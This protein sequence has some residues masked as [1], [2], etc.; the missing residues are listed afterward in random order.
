M[1]N[2]Q[3]FDNEIRER[4][5]AHENASTQKGDWEAVQRLLDD[6]NDTPVMAGLNGSVS[7]LRMRVILAAS[8][9]LLAI[10]TFVLFL[11]PNQSHNGTNTTDQTVLLGSKENGLPNSTS[12]KT[13]SKLRDNNSKVSRASKEELEVEISLEQ[14]KTLGMLDKS[15][16]KPIYAKSNVHKRIS[17]EANNGGQQQKTLDEVMSD[18]KKLNRSYLS[19]KN[20]ADHN[21]QENRIGSILDSVK[22]T[23]TNPTALKTVDT[24]RFALPT[25][26]AQIQIAKKDSDSRE[27]KTDTTTLLLNLA[28]VEKDT[29]SIAANLKRPKS[30]KH[31]NTYHVTAGIGYSTYHH[32]SSGQLLGEVSYRY[33]RNQLFIEASLGYEQNMFEQVTSTIGQ[34]QYFLEK[35]EVTYKL[36]IYR[37]SY[38]KN[39]LL[40]GYQINNIRIYSG[41]T[42]GY[43]LNSRASLQKTDAKGNQKYT[44]LETQ[45]YINGLNEFTHGLFAGGEYAIG[46]ISLGLRAH[47]YKRYRV[48]AGNSTFN[49]FQFYAKYMFK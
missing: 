34:Q 35:E 45:G 39:I 16:K 46:K 29:T 10:P 38:L 40:V 5:A 22:H 17:H 20:T 7:K 33:N 4:F 21:R 2:E 13:Q 14:K 26:Q 36:N 11:L 9:I 8:I 27:L 1:S 25:E 37:T 41:V 31:T 28:Q 23:G 43:L 47:Y 48:I 44:P 32:N 30:G 3:Q 12:K 19:T 49:D 42:V 15:L 6:D 18:A 24:E